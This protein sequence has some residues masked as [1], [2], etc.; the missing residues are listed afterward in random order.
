MGGD[1]KRSDGKDGE[2]EKVGGEEMETDGDRVRGEDREGGRG[3]GGKVVRLGHLPAAATRGNL[4]SLCRE[5]GEVEEV[6]VGLHQTISHHASGT[7]PIDLFISIV[8]H[9]P[10]GAREAE[11]LRAHP[12]PGHLRLPPGGGQGQGA[13]GGAGPG[14]RQD[15]CQGPAGVARAPG[16]SFH[17]WVALDLSMRNVWHRI[18]FRLAVS[19][20]SVSEPQTVRMV[21]AKLDHSRGLGGVGWGHNALHRIFGKGVTSLSL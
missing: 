1:K 16:D 5:M 18:A 21:L 17:I 20:V 7:P 19:I 12:R 15:L 4:T 11:A 6:Q 14:R 3:R 13:A 10:D 8:H 2:E 9:A